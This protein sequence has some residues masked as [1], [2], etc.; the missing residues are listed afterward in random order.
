MA[1]VPLVYIGGFGDFPLRVYEL[2]KQTGV[3]TRRGGD[4]NGG[5]SP[6]YLAL[7][8]SGQYLYNVNE[9]DGEFAGL[10][11]HHIKVD[12]TLEP[13]NHQ[14]GTDKTPQQACNGSCGFTH[15][16]VD[17]GGH[18][19]V[20]A[21]YNG[22]SISSF[23]ISQDGS[24]GPEKAL[25]DFGNQAQ[26]HSVAFDASGKYA[27]VPTLGLDRVQQ[28]LLG[29]DGALSANLPANVASQNGAGPR[30][31]ALHPNGKLAFVVN[32]TVSSVTPYAVSADG[33]L[34]PGASV[35]S[36][37]AGFNG[38]SY[39]QHVEVS[40]DGRFVYASNVGHDSIAVFSVDVGSGALTHLQDQ[41]S[42]GAWPRDFD[43]D[44]NGDV[45]VVAN[46]DSNSLCVFAI[47]QD[48]K[49]SALGGP[50]TVPAE[51]SSVLIRYNAN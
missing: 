37:P 32:E 18:F 51:P 14:A 19:V 24:L 8:P 31:I 13:L 16:A 3:L 5:R 28:L 33:K 11:A 7:S 42:G 22:G 25:L 47:G 23:P 6:S 26:A 45:L 46:R 35:S 38:E 48:G 44:P 30:H 34:T 27:F 10:T 43:V 2:N 9:D 17:P 1:G 4:E 49:L 20:A 41:P 40:P 21:N 12:G 50:T 15:L 39:G 36:L 29:N